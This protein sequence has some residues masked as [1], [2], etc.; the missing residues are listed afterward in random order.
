[1]QTDMLQIQREMIENLFIMLYFASTTMTME[2]L[3]NIPKII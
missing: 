2:A 3:E 1:M